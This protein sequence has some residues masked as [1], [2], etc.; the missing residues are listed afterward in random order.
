MA[1]LRA[2]TTK[3]HWS[4]Q[5]GRAAVSGKSRSRF[6]RLVRTMIG[7][8]RL[9]RL[10]SS[11][12]EEWYWSIV[13]QLVGPSVGK[14]SLEIGSAPG[15]FSVELHRR[16]GC[17]PFGV[18]YTAEGARLNRAV[19]EQAG[20]NPAN[21][22]VDDFF[23]DRF[24]DAHRG[25]FDIVMSRGFIE[26]FSDPVSVLRHHAELLKPGG[27]LIVT[28]PRLR[29]LGYALTRLIAPELLSKHNLDIMSFAPFQALFAT[30]AISPLYC[31]LV[32][33]I[34]VQSYTSASERY[35]VR[36]VGATVQKLLD[37]GLRSLPFRIK[38]ES[39]RPQLLCIGTNG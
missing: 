25:Q 35:A 11:Y 33:G 3:D 28:I 29:G 27:F 31:G 6:K 5:I 19:F 7:S 17:E 16:V 38:S 37:L 21:V 13:A 32:S 9:D 15:T 36:W 4:K 30:L 2:L 39:V 1:P 24:I 20:I 26:H 12:S 22:I 10:T 34:G 8:Q 14:R 18:E 23:N